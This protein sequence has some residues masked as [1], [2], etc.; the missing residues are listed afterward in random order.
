MVA[1]SSFSLSV[2]FN[3]CSTIFFFL[4]EDKQVPSLLQEYDVVVQQ[5][6]HD[7]TAATAAALAHM[8]TQM[9]EMFA[10]VGC[11]RCVAWGVDFIR[12]CNFY[13]FDL[14]CQHNDK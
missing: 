1:S 10:Q 6:H 7:D 3:F 2:Y 12:A 11:T 5:K 9:L 14:M 8:K 4:C 13:I